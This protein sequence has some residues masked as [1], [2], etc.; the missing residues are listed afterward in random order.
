MPVNAVTNEIVLA[1]VGILLLVSIIQCVIYR[2]MARQQQRL[3]QFMRMHGGDGIEQGLVN[4]TRRLEGIETRLEEVALWQKKTEDE[5]AGCV[6][7]PRVFRYNAFEDVGSKLSF[8]TAFLDAR[9]EGAVLTSLYSRTESR[10]YCKPVNGGTSSF[11]LTG[12]EETVIAR[13]LNGGA[14]AD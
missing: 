6:R 11:P 13:S 8:S 1:V 2:R 9:G 10:T 3:L 14:G 4:C 12:E 7:A 5:L